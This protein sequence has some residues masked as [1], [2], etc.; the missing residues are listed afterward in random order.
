MELNTFER[1]LRQEN[2]AENTI[3]AYMYAI[4]DYYTRFSHLNKENL[5]IYKSLL[6]ESNKPG[7]VNLRI[8]ALNKYLRSIGKNKLQLKAVKV[9][10]GS[11]LENVI[12]T[13]EYTFLKDRLREEPNR[14]WYFAIRFMAATG[15]RVSELVRL[16]VEHV[17]AGYFDICSKGG[18]VRRLYIPDQ[19][20]L[21]TLHWLDRDSGYLFLNRNGERITTRG[22]AERLSFYAEKYGMDVSKVHPHSFRHLYAKRFLDNCQ[23]IALLADLLGH[24]N[25]STTRRYLRKNSTEQRSLINRIVDW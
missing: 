3:V 13:D 25:I 19:L 21:E 18:K 24:S 12:T 22:I 14:E 6:I 9:Q 5:L 23:D 16:R 15:A 7:T 11:F 1:V 20:R 2:Y 8:Q 10:E 4:R 17:Q